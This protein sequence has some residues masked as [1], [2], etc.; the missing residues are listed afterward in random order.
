MASDRDNELIAAHARYA[1]QAALSQIADEKQNVARTWGEQIAR[2]DSTGA[3]WTLRQLATLAAEEQMI[4]GA[5]AQQQQVQ[6]PQQQSPY[7][8]AEIEWIR[9]NENVCRDPKKWAE[10]IAAANSLIARGADRNSDEY[11][12]GIELAIGLV[13][14]D[15]KDGPEILSP[16]VVSEISRS[17]Y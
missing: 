1:Q 14:A 4:A 3:A 11:L 6:Q 9:R 12:H 2:G 16:E 15:G 10:C 13:G 17:Q 8:Q 7:T 5:P